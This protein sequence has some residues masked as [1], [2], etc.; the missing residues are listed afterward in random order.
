MTEITARH[1]H[2]SGIW[3]LVAMGIVILVAVVLSVA[4][5]VRHPD[6]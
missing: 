2:G 1:S 6:G 4:A 3:M 5:L